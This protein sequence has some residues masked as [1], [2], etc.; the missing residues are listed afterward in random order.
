MNKLKPNIDPSLY[1][2]DDMASADAV[3]PTDNA[4][5]PLDTLR[6]E[7]NGFEEFDFDNPD[8]KK[9]FMNIDPLWLYEE[10]HKVDRVRFGTM[11]RYDPAHKCLVTGCYDE[12]FNLISYKHRKKWGKKWLPRKG[13]HPNGH[14]LIRILRP[15][16]GP[17]YIVEGHR[18][19]LSALLLGLNFIMVP[20]AGFRLKE[21]SIVEQEVAG[22]DLVFIV[23]DEAAHKCMT[24][25]AE[26]LKEAAGKIQL[27]ELSNK[28]IKVDLSDYIKKFNDIEGVNNGLR[29]RR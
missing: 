18:D 19:A 3:V 27:I 14:L 8:H 7:F 13:T 12:K 29:N 21:S 1:K 2:L 9:A 25:I 10:S 22:Y 23:E 16:E 15:R 5:C 26:Q 20:Y 4:E 11:V 24:K 28:N 17:V 6:D